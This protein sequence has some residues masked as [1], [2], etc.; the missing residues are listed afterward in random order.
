M[1]MLA[2]AAAVLLAA[3]VAGI[4]LA[5]QCFALIT[6]AGASMEPTLRPGDQVLVRR[7]AAKALRVGA[8]VVFREPG[9]QHRPGTPASGL[10]SQPWAIKRIAAMPGH[11]VPSS[12][13]SA[14]GGTDVVPAGML[15]VLGDGAR[16]GDSRQWGFIPA[17]QTL[18]LMVRNL[19]TRRTSGRPSARSAGTVYSEHG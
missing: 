2:V 15:V 7:H 4:M 14:V 3:C 1:T 5:R 12:V 6:V 17:D 19:T 18:G 13:R 16:S 9:G 11:V 8:I 10:A